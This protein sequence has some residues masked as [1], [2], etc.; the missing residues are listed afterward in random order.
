MGSD[1]DFN[2]M[3]SITVISLCMCTISLRICKEMADPTLMNYAHFLNF[4]GKSEFYM[5]SLE[6]QLEFIKKV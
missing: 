1:L 4:P 6:Q 3:Y 5:G 2:R